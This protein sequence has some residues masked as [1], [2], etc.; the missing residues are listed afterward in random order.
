MSTDIE[1][2]KINFVDSGKT[3]SSN[4]ITEKSRKVLSIKKSNK[5]NETRINLSELQPELAE[6]LRH[7]DLGNNGY[8]DIED[9]IVLDEKEKNQEKLVKD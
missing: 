3:D 1:F 9:I 6:K 5:S 4:E 8:I 2:N 7:L